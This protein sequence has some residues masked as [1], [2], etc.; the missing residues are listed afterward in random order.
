[1][2]HGFTVNERTKFGNTPLHRAAKNGQVEMVLAG[3][4][5][6]GAQVDAKNNDGLTPLHEAACTGHIAIVNE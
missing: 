5:A 2:T 6:H 1:M 4:L 3:L